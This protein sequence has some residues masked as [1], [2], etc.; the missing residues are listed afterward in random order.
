ME[1][2]PLSSIFKEL[3]AWIAS[4]GV[5]FAFVLSLCFQVRAFAA[6]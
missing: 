1:P 6:G 3:K 5:I 4:T 2:D